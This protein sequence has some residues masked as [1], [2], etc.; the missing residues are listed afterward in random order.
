MRPLVHLGD[1]FLAKGDLAMAE[2]SFDEVYH[3]VKDPAVSEW[4]KWRYS[5][6]LFASLGELW[7]SRGNPRKAQEF[8]DQCLEI[9]KRT[10]SRKYLVKGW[11]LQG[12]IDLAHRQWDEAEGWLR[13]ALLLAREVGN[14][15][16]LWKTY[17][18]M[19]RV[20]TAREQSAQAQESYQAARD[21]IDRIKV[22]L[23]DSDLRENFAQSPLIRQVYDLSI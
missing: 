20:Q 16:Q 18:T 15:P 6:H 12:E 11:R 5:T 21:V 9:A 13:Q 22:G 1:I 8:V 14:P 3:M 17:L 23:I 10:N 7:M 19:A 2:E 4:M